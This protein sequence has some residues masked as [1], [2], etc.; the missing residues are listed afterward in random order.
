ML[1]VGKLK[2]W[3]Y[4]WWKYLMTC[5]PFWHETQWKIDKKMVYPHLDNERNFV[6]RQV[7]NFKNTLQ[8]RSAVAA[9][10]VGP[11]EVPVQIC[12]AQRSSDNARF[13]SVLYFLTARLIGNPPTLI[14][15]NWRY[16]RAICTTLNEK[17][18]GR[19]VVFVVRKRVTIV[20][21]A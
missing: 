3:D 17:A 12:W 21:G 6:A 7:R 11:R 14:L 16:F 5:E 8:R 19:V 15:H 4:K 13:I 1:G 2:W 10:D 18:F 20:R 9:V